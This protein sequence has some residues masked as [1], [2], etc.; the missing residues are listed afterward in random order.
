MRKT[1]LLLLL[2]P[3]IHFGFGQTGGAPGQ[4]SRQPASRSGQPVSTSGQP[5][6]TSGQPVLVKKNGYTQLLVDGRPFVAVAGELHNSTSSG[7]AYFS[8]ALK[9]ARSMNINTVIATVSWEQFEPQEGKYDYQL[10]DTIIQKAAAENLKLVLIWFAS[11]KNG[12]SAYAPAWVKADPK[13]F[14]RVKTRSGVD[15]HT[16]SPFCTAAMQADAKAFSML[17]KRIKEKDAR[18]NV[19][20][21]Q[22]E[23]EVGAFSE[24]DYNEEALK[25]Y[26]APVP[27]GLIDYVSKNENTLAPELRDAWVKNGRRT[28]GN[29]AAVFGEDNYDAQNFFMSWQYATYINRVCEAGKKEYAIPMYVNCWLVQ[30]PGERPGEYPNGGPVSRVMDI[31]KAAAP[32]ID[33]CSPDIYLKN[34]REICQMYYRPEKNNP[35][36]IPECEG[37]NPGKAYY[38]IGECNAIGFSPFGVESLAADRS[39]A[40]SFAV[41][42]EMM[43]LIRQYQGTGK[44]RGVLKEGAKDKDTLIMGQYEIEVRYR[45]KDQ[46]CYGIIVQTGEDEFVV[47]GINL[48]LKFRCK[49]ER[50]TALVGQVQEG[51]MKGGRWETIRLLNG[52]ESGSD[53]T[54]NVPGRYYYTTIGKESFTAEAA[55]V[56]VPGLDSVTEGGVTKYL[57]KAPGVYKVSV[58]TVAV[59]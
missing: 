37:D 44:M 49:D 20:M 52:D 16:I 45:A 31:Y 19:I 13:R 21:M 15:V 17:M 30:H 4:P 29:W 58:L 26:G 12:E 38:A 56:H 25:L 3:G 50:R 40:Q 7:T 2:W 46:D 59:L 33:F 10:V 1:I 6:S 9:Y 57:V 32:A 47:G 48:Q 42:E 11:W 34:F 14:V 8:R 39:Y 41:L 24:M 27:A 28:K 51:S 36:F 23:N 53:Y 35:L 54:A 18:H 55:W 22:V 5:V 43:P